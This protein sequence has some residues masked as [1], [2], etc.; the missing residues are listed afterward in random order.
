MHNILSTA[1]VIFVGSEVL[2]V[3]SSALQLEEFWSTVNVVWVYIYGTH[4]IQNYKVNLIK[5]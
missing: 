3:T 5:I 4:V 1:S 2:L